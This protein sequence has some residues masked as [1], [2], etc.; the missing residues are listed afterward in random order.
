[1]KNRIAGTTFSHSFVAE[2]ASDAHWKDLTKKANALFEDENFQQAGKFYETAYQEAEDIFLS[3]QIGTIYFDADPAPMLISSATNLAENHFQKGD[4]KL[5]LYALS[6]ALE[7][8]TTVLCDPGAP[9]VFAE[10]CA[11]HLGYGV[12]R[13]ATLMRNLGVSK[14]SATIEI[15]RAKIAFLNFSARQ[16]ATK[17]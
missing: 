7:R 12:T 16:T 13:L 9:K 1:M 8:L 5:A 2:E 6:T 14:K 11:Q 4:H 15:E 17:H 10:Q 3:A